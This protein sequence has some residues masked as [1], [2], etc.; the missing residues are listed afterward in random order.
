[1]IVSFPERPNASPDKILAWNAWFPEHAIG[2]DTGCLPAVSINLPD[3]E[4]RFKTAPLRH[5]L[6]G[7]LSAKDKEAF[8]HFGE[9]GVGKSHIALN[10]IAWLF[11]EKK[12]DSAVVVAPKGVYRNWVGEITQHLPGPSTIA[13]WSADLRASEK[14]ALKILEDRPTGIP[15]LLVNVEALST[16]KGR[17]FLEHFLATHTAYVAVDES[18]TIKNYRAARTK[19]LIKMGRHAAYRRVLSGDPAANSPMDLYGQFEFLGNNILG[20]D[21]FFTFQRRYCEMFKMRIPNRPQHK[22]PNV[23]KG[24]RNLEALRKVI[25]PFSFIV[26]KSDT[27]DLPQ[28]I[29]QQREVFMTPRQTAAYNQ[30]RDDMLVEFKTLLGENNDLAFDNFGDGRSAAEG[31]DD[32]Q[33][34]V[35]PTGAGSG[36]SG[37]SASVDLFRK[38]L[39]GS[40]PKI[41]LDRPQQVSPKSQVVTAQIVLTKILRLDQITC[42]FLRA[43]DGS[44]VAADTTNPRIEALMEVLEQH[45]GKAIIWANYRYSIAEIAAEIRR[46]YGEDSVVTYFGD[47][48][49]DDREIAKDRFQNDPTCRWFVGNQQT[50]GRGLTLTAADLVVFFSND[51]DAERRHQAEDRPYRIGQ[52]KNVVIM[53]LVC[54]GTVNEKILEAHLSKDALSRLITASSWRELLAA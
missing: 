38:M 36:D 25:E 35:D 53:D 50:G 54:R 41:T 10:E 42:G 47:T 13:W 21:S 12:I 2:V 45:Q 8:A 49:D 11:Q 6:R 18:T 9:M 40:L 23:V 16:E 5:Q 52:T 39:A 30:M 1:M 31:E 32:G 44:I 15:V 48:T 34:M 19:A 46:V 26:K 3:I 22:W 29:Y 33:R 27:L 51:Y 43:D 14:K 20:H 4:Y 37:P 24:F 17:D 28:K 7:W